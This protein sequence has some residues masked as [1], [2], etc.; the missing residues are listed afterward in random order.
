MIDGDTV[1]VT[2]TAN[3]ADK[4]AGTDKQVDYTGVALSGADA[5]NYTVATTATGAGTID[6]AD[7]TFTVESYTREYDG[8][9]SA[10]GATLK[11][12]GTLYGTDSVSGGVFTLDSKDA[13]ART[14]AVSDV[15]INDGN[16]GNN[17]NVTY[18]DGTGE[19]TR[20][21]LELVATPQTITEGEATPTFTGSVTG[22]VENEGL[23]NESDLAFALEDPTAAAAGKYAVTG[24]L[25]GNASGDYG[26]NYTF[27]NAAANATAFTIA[28]KY[29]PPTPDQTDPTNPNPAPTTTTELPT[30]LE[31]IVGNEAT[32]KEY[33]DTIV[34]L[35][36]GAANTL[37]TSEERAMTV[38]R[39]AQQT[40]QGQAAANPA[41]HPLDISYGDIH[42]P[43]SMSAETLAAQLAGTKD[44][45]AA[46]AV[47]DRTTAEEEEEA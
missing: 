39:P 4:N 29:I 30:A 9:D 10:E 35:E 40:E 22:F 6:K 33:R 16:N 2:G 43:E 32:A 27:G 11:T 17:Y 47:A 44:A 28:A 13:G 41:A 34:A 12:V 46:A 26:A 14:I 25:N 19:I 21:A 37:P 36:S 38:L 42:M 5:G 20:K 24:T 45:L 7:V 15:A 18:Q 31:T 3:F 1:N 8:T 23:E